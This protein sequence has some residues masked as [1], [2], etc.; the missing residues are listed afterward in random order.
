MG[1]GNVFN[2]PNSQED[3]NQFSF[4]LQG[5]LRDVSRRILELNGPIVAEFP[6]DPISTSEPGVQL[7]G[8]QSMMDQIN[9]TLNL[10]G[11]NYIDVD[12]SDEG[13]KTAWVWLLANNVRE[14]A[15][16]VGVG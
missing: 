4:S 12:L 5:V 11:F 6:L 14:A 3:W 9:S 13:Q 8:I 2:V 16:A 15:A 10:Q 7:E 1:L